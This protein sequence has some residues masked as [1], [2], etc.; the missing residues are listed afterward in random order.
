MTT[1]PT[2]LEEHM[3]VD[4]YDLAEVY[5]D[6]L[7]ADQ[8]GECIDLFCHPCSWEDPVIKEGLDHGDV[9]QF[10]VALDYALANWDFSQ[11]PHIRNMLILWKEEGF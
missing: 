9:A 4:A 1:G 2:K 6:T 11:L 10:E 8:Q 7:P 5:V 3:Q